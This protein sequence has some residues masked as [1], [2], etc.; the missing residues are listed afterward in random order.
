MLS[1]I[2]EIPHKIKKGS[3]LKIDFVYDYESKDENQAS[4][5][6]HYMFSLYHD[7]DIQPLSYINVYFTKEIC[8]F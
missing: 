6:F 4:K 3:M 2:I 1:T 5:R 7:R 8:R